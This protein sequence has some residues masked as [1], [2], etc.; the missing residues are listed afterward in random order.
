M[1]KLVVLFS[2]MAF[3]MAGGLVLAHHG[4]ENVTFSAKMGAVTFPHAKHQDEYKIECQTC[5]HTGT[6]PVEKCGSCHGAK[7]GAPKMKDAA[8]DLCMGCHKEKAAGPT[9]CKDCHKK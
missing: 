2:A 9:G 3:L 6:E 1:K 4:P 7:E 8:H 5:H